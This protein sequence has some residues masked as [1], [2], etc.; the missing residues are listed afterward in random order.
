[1]IGKKWIYLESSTLHSQSMGHL[2][3]REALGEIHS[4][5]RTWAISG[6]ERE[7]RNMAWLVFMGW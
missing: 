7:P 4:T 5:D 3:R 6:G 1:M 2:G